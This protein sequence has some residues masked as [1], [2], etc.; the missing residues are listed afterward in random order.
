M[1][2]EKT[3]LTALE[4]QLI[5]L[6]RDLHQ[7]P[8]AGWT[9]YR[10]T[11]VIL[12]EM[13]QAGIPVRYGREI[14]DPARMQGLPDRRAAEYALV[15]AAEELGGPQHIQEMEGGFTGCVACI[16]G[17][18]QG[19]TLAIRVDI[20]CNEVEESQE[21]GHRPA[22]EA[23]ASRHPG[24]MH[25]C[26][27]DGHAAIGVGAARLLWDH[28]DRLKGRVRII[29]QPAEEGLRGAASLTAAGVLDG[30][31]VLLGAHLGLGLDGVGKIATAT[32]GFLASSKL[33]VTFRGLAAHAGAC[34][35]EGRNALAAAAA[36]V[37]NLLAISRHGDG[38]SR[39]NIGSLHADGGRNVIP[40]LAV[41]SLE[42]RG[43][44]SKINCYMEQA[45]LRVCRSAAE[46][47]GCSCEER[48][49]GGAGTAV[50]SP[51]LAARAAEILRNL[52][53]V[54]EI[55]PDRYFGGGEDITVM[56]QAVQER[57]G[58][59]TEMIL[60]TTIAAPHHNGRFDFDESVLLLGA[61]AFAALA[62]EL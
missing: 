57:G 6:R 53:G 45:A 17:A 42:T 21:E 24:L 26:G 7:Y 2:F 29:F 49:V 32:H 35:Q 33:D 27:H 61:R 36:A 8:E 56:M 60:G 19:P 55:L 31:G 52:D 37:T 40:P 25:A 20:D 28:R 46:M 41:M 59:A 54:A 48:R 22:R 43:A 18:K 4:R 15:R 1:R 13:R 10:T 50:C 9:E 5:R 30:C 39:I 14:H 62:L 3:N 11:A 23:F 38:A 16:D 51:V 44:D 34:P 58:Q 47:Y 12:R